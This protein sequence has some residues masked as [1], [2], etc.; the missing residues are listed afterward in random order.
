MNPEF[1][2]QLWLQFSPQRLVLMPLVLGLCFLAT[3]VS[4]QQGLAQSLALCGA[5]LFGVLVFGL[6]AYAASDSVLDEMQDHTWDQQRMSALTPWTVAWGKLFGATAYAWY[7]GAW[8]LLVAIPCGLA[9]PSPMPVLSLVA[10]GILCG[11]F[12]HAI[13]IA[14]NLQMVRAGQPI[15]RR[16]SLAVLIVLWLSM[17]T[18]TSINTDAVLWWGHTW[19]AYGF[20]LASAAVFAACALV[21]AS[22][23]MSEVMAQRQ[24]PWGLPLGVLVLAVYVSGFANEGHVQMVGW[25]G[26]VISLCIGYGSL[27]TEPQTR[28]TWQR[29]VL[30]AREGRWTDVAMLAPRWVVVLCLALPFAIFNDVAGSAV[31]TA[32]G[33][34]FWLHA[35]PL[36]LMALRDGLL[37]MA[38]HAAAKGRRPVF[39][40]LVTMLCLYLLL[41]WLVSATQQKFAVAV[42]LPW[43][44]SNGFIG[45]GLALVHVAIAGAFLR[46]RWRATA[47]V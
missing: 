22:R 43:T 41:P 31:R 3:A 47:H 19:E 16:S 34:D 2:R 40:F 42:V 38:L 35:V 9:W 1:Q 30:R 45:A 37:A 32:P 29:I 39:A 8:C 17:S 27:L 15:R 6:G 11:I 12:L 7:G 13:L 33:G 44:A 36:V 25:Y 24:L 46:W 21:C 20:L 18:V 4:S 28:P 14:L 26:L 23:S 10:I 5:V